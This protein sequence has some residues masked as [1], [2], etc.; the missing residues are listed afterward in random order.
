MKRS[1]FLGVGG[2]AI[3]AALAKDA[4]GAVAT[5]TN[6]QLVQFRA[7]DGTAYTSQTTLQSD[8]VLILPV[9]AN[10]ATTRALQYYSKP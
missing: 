4:R 9:Q 1:T 8:D 7:T 3:L 10:R 5:V 2:V 6:G